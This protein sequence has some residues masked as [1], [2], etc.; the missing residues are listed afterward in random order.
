M[1]RITFPLLL[2]IAAFCLLCAP[3]VTAGQASPPEGIMVRESTQDILTYDYE[4]AL[5][6]TEP[7]DPIYPYPRIDRTRIGRTQMRS[8]RILIVENRFLKLTFLPELG[9]RL[10]QVIDKT[11][12]QPL[13]YQNPVIKPSYF[14]QRGWWIGAG[15]MEW[16]APTEEHGYLEYLPWDLT[17][18]AQDD[19]VTVHVT[20]TE[21]QTGMQVAASVTLRTNERRFQVA[22]AVTN[23]TTETHPLQMWTNAM[24]APGGSNRIGN[25]MAFVVP[26]NQMIVHAAQDTR[27]PAPHGLMPWPEIQGQ[28]MRYL[29]NWDG[30]LGAFTPQPVPFFGIYD[31]TLN[32]GVAIVQGDGATGAKIF[33]MSTNFDRSLFT[34][35]GS[36]YVEL[37]SGAQRTFWDYPPLES[38][39]TRTINT[40]WLPLHGSGELVAASGEGALG[41][42]QHADGRTSLSLTSA[43]SINNATV[44]VRVA[45]QEVYRSAEHDL[46]PDQP[47]T[48][49]LPAN[50]RGANERIEVQ[51]GA[52]QL[53]TPVLTSRCFDET[54]Q[55]I[56]G[57]IREFWEQNGG[58]PVFGYPITPQRL[59]TIEGK[60]LQVQWFERNRLELHPENAR[61]Y[62]VLL[63]RLGVDALEQQQRT[64]QAFPTSDPQSGCHFFEQTQQN[65]CG[66]ILATWQSSGLELD[67]QAGKTDAESLALFG[68]PVSPLQ[69]EIIDGNRRQV[70]WFERARFELHPE[71]APPYNVLLGLLGRDM[72]TSQ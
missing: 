5:V 72:H 6:D 43:R 54:G 3:F 70:Q 20:T 27:V 1:T 66:D 63:G 42:V 32:M 67:G 51:A 60:S 59:E 48:I 4:Q 26:S 8:Y 16:A 2:A 52:L 11:T 45:G 64:W 55:C 25:G 53:A 36:D 28:D 58:L 19:S 23:T 10:Y 61:P 39:A 24:L 9:G 65:V 44:V 38:G 56:D 13:F 62:D 69:P 15:G 37:W 34:D 14:G 30:Y 57:R 40:T 7:D 31:R 18:A 17:W 46:R 47:L 50:V 12:G 68:L 33:G 21:Q 22:M 71:N 29:V 35:D 49:D 41:R